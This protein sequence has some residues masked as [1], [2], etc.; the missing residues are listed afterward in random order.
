ML[1]GILSVEHTGTVAVKN[2]KNAGKT[3]TMSRLVVADA[4]GDLC[5]LT[6]WEH[7]PEDGVE[8]LARGDVIYATSQ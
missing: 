7:L 8:A 3:V 2:G 6:I 5:K 1:V 4:Q